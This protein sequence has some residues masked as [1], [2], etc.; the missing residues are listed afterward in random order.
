[1][2]SIFLPG[3]LRSYKIWLFELI[4]SGFVLLLSS[5]ILL[6]FAQLNIIP[7]F[8]F[9]LFLLP[10]VFFLWI[11]HG[12][13]HLIIQV[14]SHVSPPWRCCVWPHS[15]QRYPTRYSLQYYSANTSL[16]CLSLTEI[17]FLV[18]FLIVFLLPGTLT[19]LS[20]L[21]ETMLAQSKHSVRFCWICEFS[22][23]ATF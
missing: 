7:G 1:M 6:N 23:C 12:W 19:A 11:F 15:K 17:F 21:P 8:L 9:L 20:L 5:Y 18:F 13:F 3:P 22:V 16:Q 10:E 4:F 2:K 14:S